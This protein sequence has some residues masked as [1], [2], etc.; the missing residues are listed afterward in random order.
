MTIIVASL[1]YFSL[2]Y[3]FV[4]RIRYYTRGTFLAFYGG[5]RLGYTR[6]LTSFRPT[7]WRQCVPGRPNWVDSAVSRRLLTR[8][9]SKLSDRAACLHSPLAVGG[10]IT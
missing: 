6:A 2:F 4:L 9:T 10:G 5:E 1:F 3:I 8:M 7:E